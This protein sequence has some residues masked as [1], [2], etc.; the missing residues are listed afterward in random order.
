VG[1]HDEAGVPIDLLGSYQ[2]SASSSRGCDAMSW[3]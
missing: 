1:R 3:H 2:L